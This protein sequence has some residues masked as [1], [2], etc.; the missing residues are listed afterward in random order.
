MGNSGP[1]CCLEVE[2]NFMENTE[3]QLQARADMA[4]HAGAG[5]AVAKVEVGIKGGV[6]ARVRWDAPDRDMC[7]WYRRI[8][9]S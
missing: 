4:A 1:S 8:Q 5:L 3:H 6:V 9:L 2:T 7:R